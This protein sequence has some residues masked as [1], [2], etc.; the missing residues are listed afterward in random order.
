MERAEAAEEVT[1]E[2]WRLIR[3]RASRRENEGSKCDSSERIVIVW[4][5]LAV[6]DGKEMVKVVRAVAVEVVVIVLVKKT[7]CVETVTLKMVM[8][9]VVV[10]W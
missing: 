1:V 9:E 10:D 6:V 4:H 5:G 2:E 8:S 7:G 3:W